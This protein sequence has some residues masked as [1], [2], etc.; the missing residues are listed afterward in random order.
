VT[1]EGD[2]PPLHVRAMGV[3]V[4]IN[5]ADH[6]SRDRLARQWVRALVEPDQPDHPPAGEPPPIVS[7]WSGG[8][9]S[10]SSR[11]Y[12]VTTRVTMAALQATA[13][14]RV[15]LHAGGVADDQ[16][17]LLALVAPSGT[18]KTTA[19][20]ALSTQLG[21]VSDETVSVDPDGTVHPHPK[22]L[23]VLHDER[24]KYEK[25]QLSPD[26]LELLPT[27]EK[28]R[29]ARLVVLHRGDDGARGLAPLPIGHALLQ[30]VEQS[31]SMSQLPRPLHTL[32]GLVLDCGGAWAL[33]YD[34]ITDHVDE[35]VA[36]L[37]S[38]PGA[39]E[40]P[41]TLVWHERQEAFPLTAGDDGPLLARRPFA[42]AVEIDDELVVLTDSHAWLLAEMTL[43][44]WLRLAAP[45]TL[46][47][48]VATAEEAYGPHERSVE[49]VRA[50][51]TTLAQEELVGWGSLT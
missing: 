26:D 35:L 50:A 51:V 10:E 31:S 1:A 41:H 17:R 45:C 39:P 48:L 34:E 23:S 33:T 18:G 30:L 22:P 4:R 7:T 9:D 2:V 12:G 25:T 27:P 20:R 49:I 46:A 6:E 40:P 5:V 29:L 8:A 36:F 24:P 16:G 47:D 3:T 21:Y 32:L 13:G 38:A 37:A 14:R 28:P 19:T 43:T 44:I 15:N 42:E 11:D